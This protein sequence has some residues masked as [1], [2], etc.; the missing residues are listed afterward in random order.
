MSPYLKRPRWGILGGTFNPVHLGHLIVAEWMLDA[1]QLN[2]VLFVPN[3]RHPFQKHKEI[4]TPRRRLKMLELATDDYPDFEVSTLELDRGDISYTIDTLRYMRDNNP[5]TELFYL[6]GEDNVPEFDRWKEPRNILALATVVVYRRKLNT[7][8]QTPDESTPFMYM[9][10]PIIEISSSQIRERI[11]QNKS[12][13][14]LLPP[15]VYQY[16]REHR[17]Y[18][19]S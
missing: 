6:I 9:D 16:I 13:R 8:N 7:T 17:L 18:N 14:S 2:K 15:G 12:C 1:L 10:T 19:P 11:R 4:T 5:D 3:Y